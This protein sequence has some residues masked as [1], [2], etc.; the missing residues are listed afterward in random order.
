MN[1][2]N[3]CP[4]HLRFCGFGKIRKG[5]YG[6]LAMD[7]HSFWQGDFCVGGGAEIIFEKYR[8]TVRPN[9]ILIIPPGVTHMFRY[10]SN[11]KFCCYSFKFDLEEKIPGKEY[12]PKLISGRENES[13]RRT[14][15]ECVSAIFHSIF[16][17]KYWNQSLAFATSGVWPYISLLENLLYG[18]LCNFYFDNQENLSG[19]SMLVRKIREY[20]VLRD[21]APVSLKEL[22]E[23]F[24]YTPN[25]LSTLIFHETGIRA[26]YFIDRERVAAAQRFLQ[27]SNLKINE[28]A[29]LMGFRDINYFRKFY[30]RITGESPSSYK[31]NL[32]GS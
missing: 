10:F 22:A 18:I 20:I 6:R 8:L 4:L 2:Q 28:L 1:L 7:S 26:K 17:E 11:E 24:E 32:K 5:D 30:K 19:K 29:D 27:Y 14:S 13:V 31:K 12:I 9:D 15:L 23:H 16:P 3:T 21:G 25:Y